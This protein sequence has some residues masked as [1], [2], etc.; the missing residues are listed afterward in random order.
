MEEGLGE[1]GLQLGKGQGRD[2]VLGA[3]RGGCGV[4]SPVKGL[5]GGE[6]SCLLA[7]FVRSPTVLAHAQRQ[8]RTFLGEKEEE[9]E[10]G[11]PPRRGAPR[12]APL[13]LAWL[14]AGAGAEPPRIHRRRPV[15]GVGV[16]QWA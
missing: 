9:E 13:L 4:Q 16:A 8:R 12:T 5:G 1:L 14:D 15:A 6:T 7:I 10:E 2:G 11:E 3:G